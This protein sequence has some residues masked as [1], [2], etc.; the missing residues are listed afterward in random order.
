MAAS[1]TSEK[2]GGTEV[3]AKRRA[4]L[5]MRIRWKIIDEI[6]RKYQDERKSLKAQMDALAAE[7]KTSE[8]AA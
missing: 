7:L 4:L 5:E 1:K 8:P 3:G 2:S 6:A